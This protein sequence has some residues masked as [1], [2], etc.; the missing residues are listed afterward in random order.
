M[1]RLLIALAGGLFGLEA[2]VAV[3]PRALIRGASSGRWRLTYPAWSE[4][5]EGFPGGRSLIPALAADP[6]QP[7]RWFALSNFGLSAKERGAAEWTR[8]SP[9]EWRG[10]HP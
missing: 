6:A 3:P 2:E 7:G 10:T 1:T 4:N 5:A 8:L 9:D